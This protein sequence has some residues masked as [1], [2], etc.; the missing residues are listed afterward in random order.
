MVK[1][2]YTR[3]SITHF[4]PIIRASRFK[5]SIVGSAKFCVI[6]V[7]P[8]LNTTLLKEC[9]NTARKRNSQNLHTLNPKTSY[10]C[11]SSYL[12]TLNPPNP[13]Y[14]HTCA[15]WTYQ[16]HQVIIPAHFEYTKH[17][18]SSYLRTLNTKNAPSSHTCT[19]W[20]YKTH[21]IILPAHF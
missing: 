4:I 19:L 10:I 20:T 7:A 2:T 15:L 18:L 3:L 14:H 11:I 6:S 1:F 16:T 8:Y 12:R 9:K 17:T 5:L 13:P 21:I